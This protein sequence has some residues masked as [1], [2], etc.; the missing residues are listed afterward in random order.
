MVAKLELVCG[1]IIHIVF[2]VVYLMIFEVGRV[3][4]GWLQGERGLRRSVHPVIHR[5]LPHSHHS[6]VMGQDRSKLALVTEVVSSTF[7]AG[8]Y[9]QPLGLHFDDRPCVRVHLWQQR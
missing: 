7:V 6:V 5:G 1:V 4:R 9:R 8:R 3:L 2:A